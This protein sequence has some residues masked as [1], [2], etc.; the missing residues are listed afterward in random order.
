MLGYDFSGVVAEAPKAGTHAV[1]DEVFGFLPY[2][3]STRGGTYAEFV[4]VGADMLGRKPTS[5]SH[6]QA[7]AA[8]TSAMTALQALNKGKLAAGQV[9]L[10]NG[11]SGGVGS[12]AV[13]IAKNLGATV[14]ATAAAKL[15]YAKGLGATRAYDYK[16]TPL[17]QIEERFD[18]ASTSTFGVCAPLLKPSGS[19]IS[20][21]PTPRL[22]SSKRCT[23]SSSSRSRP[24]SRGS[25]TGSTR[26]SS[27]RSSTR[28]T[29]TPARGDVRGKIA[30]T[31]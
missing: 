30:I 27:R 22:F 16:T 21:L 5:I 28:R 10:V 8:A 13:Q 20:L 6:E 12:Y 1:G 17:S 9:V 19:Y 18:V 26:A 25:P 31:I 2:A 24:T 23:S 15:D 11:A 14:V 29:R 7:A 4:S 3:R